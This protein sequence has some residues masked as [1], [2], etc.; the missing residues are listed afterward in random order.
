MAELTIITHISVEN[1]L[2]NTLTHRYI[3]FWISHVIF[4]MDN[5]KIT[6]QAFWMQIK[7]KCV[8][9]LGILHQGLLSSKEMIGQGKVTLYIVFSQRTEGSIE[10]YLMAFNC[11]DTDQWDEYL[12][13]SPMGTMLPIGQFDE[14]GWGRG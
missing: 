14:D 3:L 5:L 12:M 4:K 8:L 11:G 6:V 9:R 10:L 13:S 7:G 2:T 1:Y